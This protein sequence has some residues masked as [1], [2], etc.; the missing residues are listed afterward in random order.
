MRPLVARYLRL[1]I[2]RQQ[3]VAIRNATVRVDIHAAAAEAGAI[4][5]LQVTWRY[6][7][8]R[9]RLPRLAGELLGWFRH[10]RHR[11]N[12]GRILIAPR[13]FPYPIHVGERLGGCW[14]I[15][16]QT[17]HQRDGNDAGYHGLFLIPRRS[18]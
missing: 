2:R 13:L 18:V 4:G 17:Y 5:A 11:T 1:Q 14:F 15:Q 10:S 12:A 8:H 3:I 9:K 6:P 16:K 7:T